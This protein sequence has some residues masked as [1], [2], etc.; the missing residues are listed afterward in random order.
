MQ[1]SHH[2]AQQLIQCVLCVFMLMQGLC[3]GE[4]IDGGLNSAPAA[5]TEVGAE[6]RP[7]GEELGLTGSDDC[8]GG[9]DGIEHALFLLQLMMGINLG[10]TLSL[11][12]NM[13]LFR[14]EMNQL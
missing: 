9:V 4:S 3:A 11:L 8:D 2:R 13:S 1:S 10:F 14:R 6:A 12:V 7:G 5:G